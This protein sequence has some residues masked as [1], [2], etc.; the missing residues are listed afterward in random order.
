MNAALD[1]RT[2]RPAAALAAAATAAAAVETTAAASG[3][4]L[5]CKEQTP[6]YDSHCHAISE[7]R[8]L[9]RLPAVG[10]LC[11]MATGEADWP[12]LEA[13][14]ASTPVRYALG[15]HPWFLHL[16]PEGWQHRLRDALLANPAAAV[17]ETGLDRVRLSSPFPAQLEAFKVQLRLAAEL[18]R[19]LVVHAVRSDGALTDL[20]RSE[21]ALPP[22]L[23]M[24]AFG[25]SPDTAKLILAIGKKR[26]SRVFFGFSAKAARL[27]R[28]P[29]AMQAVPADCL[30]LESDED[31]ADTAAAAVEEACYRLCAARGWGK[32][33]AAARTARNARDAYVVEKSGAAGQMGS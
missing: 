30:L 31:T 19:P 25:G 5:A 7:A 9:L 6:L 8:A 18:C 2:A 10:G 17:G 29:A 20:L 22:H 3:A 21:A 15:V 12:S 27:K 1:E 26:H 23:I 4:A 11:L 28:A 33:E 13:L 32:A 16:Q 14:A 24:H